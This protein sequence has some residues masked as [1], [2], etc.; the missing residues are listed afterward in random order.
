LHKVITRNAYYPGLPIYK[1]FK[2]IRK[3]SDAFPFGLIVSVL[4]LIIC[5][6]HSKNFHRTVLDLMGLKKGH[7]NE[8][9]VELAFEFEFWYD[10]T[11]DS[12]L[13]PFRCF[14]FC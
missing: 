12:R 13:K 3:P 9:R 4:A 14:G 7:F 11:V 8:R 2:L 5:H 10:F 1:R 6:M